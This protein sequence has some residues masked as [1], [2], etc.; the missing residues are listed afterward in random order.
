MTP[1]KPI[2][3]VSGLPQNMVTL[4]F[5]LDPENPVIKGEIRVNPVYN[6]SCSIGTTFDLGFGSSVSTICKDKNPGPPAPP[7]SSNQ[8]AFTFSFFWA[9]DN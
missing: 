9:Y 5:Q 4:L 2:P 1:N 6:L 7:G 3:G 8:R